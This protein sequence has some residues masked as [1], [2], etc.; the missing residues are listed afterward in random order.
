MNR[1]HALKL[2][3][4]AAAAC[5]LCGGAAQAASAGPHWDYGTGH[6]GPAHW[7]QLS[8]DFGACSSGMQQSPIDLKSGVRAELKPV[9]L[10]YGQVPLKVVNN[11]HTIQV[12]CPDGNAMTVGSETFKLLQFH[13]HHP[14]EHRLDGRSFELERHFVHR[15]GAGDLAVLGVF[16][17]ANP[18]IDAI[19]RVMPAEAGEAAGQGAIDLNGLLPQERQ[20]FL[21]HGS[22]TTPPCSEGVHWRVL[23]APMEISREQVARFAALFPTNA[24]PVQE[25]RRRFLL[26]S[27]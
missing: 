12:D 23:P 11:G 19:W 17:A 4:G 18:V 22:L 20:H 8:A 7:G 6:G 24:R 3:A 13:F 21:Y 15:N 5:P 25:L 26:E 2:L 9:R 14:S 1:R 10:A 27:R 16:G